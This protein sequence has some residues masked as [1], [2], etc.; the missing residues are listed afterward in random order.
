MKII[1]KKRKYKYQKIAKLKIK[2][3]EHFK[4]KFDELLA[5]AILQ[6]NDEIAE[7]KK[8]FQIELDKKDLKAKELN[9][10]YTQEI[11]NIRNQEKNKYKIILEERNTEIKR[12]MNKISEN[13]ELYNSIKDIGE[14][15]DDTIRVVMSGI[16]SGEEF[17]AR[18]VQSF[19]KIASEVE[20]FKKRLDKSDTKII[21][22]LQDN[23]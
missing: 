17:I 3:K 10:F 18:G 20:G 5:Q 8:K 4:K 9:E 12:L 6:F 22:I 11:E 14:Q 23:V 16:Q 2:I 19:G 13:K 21:E 1:N 15:L 7:E